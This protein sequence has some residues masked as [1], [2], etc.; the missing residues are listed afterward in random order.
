M[1]PINIMS[2]G[3]KNMAQV[4][5]QVKTSLRRRAYRPSDKQ[6]ILFMIQFDYCVFLYVFYQ[7]LAKNGAQPHGKNCVARARKDQTHEIC[8]G[9]PKV[10]IPLLTEENLK[11]DCLFVLFVA[12]AGA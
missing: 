6:L 4:L 1:D 8:L 11:L 7:P 12:R 5:E 10:A 3:L 9:M 2:Y